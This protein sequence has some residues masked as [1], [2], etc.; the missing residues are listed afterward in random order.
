MILDNRDEKKWKVT[1]I[2]VDVLRT[3]PFP[4]QVEIDEDGVEG[5]IEDDILETIEPDQIL[6]HKQM[7]NPVV[8]SGNL[9]RVFTGRCRVT[10]SFEGPEDAARVLKW[11][12]EEALR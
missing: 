4:S 2:A 1:G 10:V 12:S 8:R 3:V 11:I 7:G 9:L 5:T 6:I